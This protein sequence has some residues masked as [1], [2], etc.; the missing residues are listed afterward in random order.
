[1]KII[2]DSAANLSP[3]KAAELNVQI[4]P[5]SITFMGK[6]YLDG[7]D[8][9][10]AELYRLYSLHPSEMSTTSQ[11]AAGQ[12]AEIYR[13]NKPEEILGIHLSSGLSG[14]YSS[15][16]T[17]QGMV[18]DA[19]VTVVDSKTVGPALGW[20]VE[21]AARGAKLGWSKEKILQTLQQVRENTIT[22]VAFSD[23][24]HLIHSGRVSHLKGIVASILRLKPI[25][26]M[27]DADGRYKSCGQAISMEKVVLRMVERVYARFG[28]QPLRIQLMHGNNLPGVDILRKAV[29]SMLTGTEDD[30]VAVTTV[31]GAHAGPTVI[32]LAVM[33]LAIWNGLGL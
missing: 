25:I 11:P 13:Q 8:I 28:N 21:A 17:A 22:M 9:L 14:T 27:N 26:G 7:V 32:G 33:P 16:T 10:P 18:P 4:V 15:A 1:M 12:F 30:L 2:T 5:F 6:T 24:S 3:E 20:M 29:Q 19:H 23:I 31:L